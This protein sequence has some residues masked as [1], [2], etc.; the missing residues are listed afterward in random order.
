MS[1]LTEAQARENYYAD[2]FKKCKNQ[3]EEMEKTLL[4][5]KEA[6]AHERLRSESLEF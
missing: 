5:A 3:L 6:F 4:S 1:K 2:A